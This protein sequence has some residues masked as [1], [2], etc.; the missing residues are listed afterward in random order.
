[1][2][3]ALR[4]ILVK[5]VMS[6]PVIILQMKSVD[7]AGIERDIVFEYELPFNFKFDQ[8]LTRTFSAIGMKNGEYIGFLFSSSEDKADFA[9]KMQ[10]V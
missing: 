3:G 7:P 8:D 4:M 9:G 6:Y 1:M 2:I 10:A 5:E